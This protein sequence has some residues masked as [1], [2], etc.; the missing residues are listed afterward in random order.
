MDHYSVIKRVANTVA[1]I[2]VIISICSSVTIWLNSYWIRVALWSNSYWY[3]EYETAIGVA[4]FVLLVYGCITAWIL[5]T[6]I[7]EYGVLVD[8]SQVIAQKLSKICT[9]ENNKESMS[10]ESNED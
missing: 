9:P 10:A 2:R 7:S 6:L 8:N 1:V 5:H 4:G 3:R